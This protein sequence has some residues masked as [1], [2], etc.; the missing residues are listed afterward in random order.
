MW[1]RSAP[2]QLNIPGPLVSNV[3]PSRASSLPSTSVSVAVSMIVTPVKVFW[4]ESVSVPPSPLPLTAVKPPSPLTTPV[5][6]TE[7]PFESIVQPPGFNTIGA[8]EV[9]IAGRPQRTAV[10]GYCRVGIAQAGAGGDQH[11]RADDRRSAGVTVIVIRQVERA[12]AAV[13][14]CHRPA[15]GDI[16]RQV[17]R[18]Q[19]FT[20]IMPPLWFST[21][22]ADRSKPL[23][24]WSVPP[25]MVICPP[26][27]AQV[28]GGSL[29]CRRGPPG[30][31]C[32]RN[33]Y[34]FPSDRAC[35]SP[36][37]RVPRKS[38]SCCRRMERC[39]S[40]CQA[41]DLLRRQSR[42]CLRAYRPATTASRRAPSRPT[43]SVP[44]D[45]ADTLPGNAA[46]MAASTMPPTIVTLPV[47]P[48]LS[49]ARTSSP[50]PSSVSEPLPVERSAKCRDEAVATDRKPRTANGDESELSKV[51]SPEPC[52]PPNV[53]VGLACRELNV[54]G[55]LV[56]KVLSL[57]GRQLVAEHER[58]GLGPT[59]ERDA[60]ESIIVAG[61]CQR[62]IGALP[63]LI[64]VRPFCSLITAGR[65]DGMPFA[66]ENGRKRRV[67]G[68]DDPWRRVLPRVRSFVAC[69]IPGS[70]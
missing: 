31:P 66:V 14:H 46:G 38:R 15:A 53:A 10:E 58:F 23:V 55:P 28:R 61:Q 24:A 33:K 39:R 54:P 40:P 68:R 5:S 20:S 11:R 63:L 19:P 41:P 21:I 22:G 1:R 18:S 59:D 29:I 13:D 49:V 52:S 6:K 16:L 48:L 50:V 45:S 32:R 30:S 70:R 27:C 36:E 9:E 67:V 64:A 4:P 34:C 17:P 47:K 3:L 42:R 12:A 51:R 44:P 62:T 37:R 25:S 57:L 60:R 43:A 35:R 69:K 26:L 65:G 7:F 2:P 8:G 56:S